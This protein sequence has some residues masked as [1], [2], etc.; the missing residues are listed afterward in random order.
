MNS[1]FDRCFD[2]LMK[3]E[4]GYVNH[5]EDPG[6][7]TNLGITKRTAL[8]F[9]YVGQMKDLDVDTAKS[10]YRHLYWKDIYDQFSFDLAFNVF[11]AGV[12]SG[13]GTS[14]KWLQEAVGVKADGVI[15][16]KTIGAIISNPSDRVVRKFN[17][18][19]LEFMTNLKTWPSFG[20]GWARRIA[21]NLVIE[22][23]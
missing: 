1:H 18:I 4:G 7:E 8:D 3:H 20:R 6:G 13:V 5:P 15:G 10:I 19:R 23:F 22:R 11:D 16:E 12:N 21:S 2:L 17:A 14:V 9:G